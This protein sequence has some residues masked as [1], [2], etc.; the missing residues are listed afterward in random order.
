MAAAFLSSVDRMLIAPLLL[1]IADDLDTTV[2][3][4]AT[5]A[6]VYFIGYGCTQVLWAFVAD[7]IGRVNALR[8]ALALG[9]LA[10]LASAAAP[11]IEILMVLRALAGASFSAAVPTA[12]TY[13][14]DSVESR[15]RHGP[16]AD[17]M[18]AT[19]LGMAAAT[20]GAAALADLMNW[21]L[22]FAVGGVLVLGLVMALRRLPE[23]ERTGPRLPIG[24]SVRR[25]VTNRWAVTVIVL[26][27]IEGALF[28]GALPFLPTLLQA[29]GMSTA[30]SGVVTAAYGAFIVVFA[31]VVKRQ[32]R[33]RSPA[34]LIG[35]GAASATAA[36]AALVVDQGAAGVF[37]ACALLAAAWAFAHSTM[38]KWITEVVPAARAVA[39][40]LF[41]SGLFLGSALGTALGSGA[42]AEGHY[43]AF[44][45]GFALAS[46]PFA[47]AVTAARRAYPGDGLTPPKQ[48]R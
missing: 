17:I 21:R 47:V 18:T 39:V 45:W 46:A 33:R 26:V 1:P 35:V 12:L 43:Q 23:P 13:V 40:S 11:T 25:V 42:V 41:A 6:T 28:L 22:P 16:L 30:L 14:G 10:T 36:F 3:A 7:R 8:L 20:L 24:A 38:Q 48:P 19:A 37:T 29:G 31:V 5:T 32:A 15:D 9:G 4:V 44:A 27:A 2:A 34:F